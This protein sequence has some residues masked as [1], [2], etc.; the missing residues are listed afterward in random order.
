MN[1]KILEVTTFFSPVV[2]GVETQVSDLSIQLIGKGY[3]VEV[4]TTNSNR[5]GGRKLPASEVIKVEQYDPVTLGSIS[6]VPINVT[7]VNTWF[8]LS[9]FHKFAPGFLLKL[10]QRDFDIVHV[11][12]IRKP[13]LYWAL[14]VAK[15]KRKKIVVSTHNPFT[16]VNRSLLMRLYIFLHDITFGV[17]LMRFVDKYVLL[18]DTEIEVLKKFGIAE[19]KMIVL[20]NALN[21]LFSSMLDESTDLVDE[22]KKT[23]KKLLLEDLGNQF[24]SIKNTSWDAI[25]F[26]TGRFNKVKGFQ[27]L[28]LAAQESP[29]SLFV[30]LGGDDGFGEQL[31]RQF[32]QSNNVVLLTEF[33]ARKELARMFRAADLF[34]LPSLHE[35]FGIVIIEA[36]SQGCAIVA[37]DSAGPRTITKNGKF[38]VLVPPANEAELSAAIKRLVEVKSDL[39]S[40]QQ[41]SL[42]RAKDF[43]W[44]KILAKYTENVFGI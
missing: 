7:R 44:N 6:N 36:M 41:L 1:Q 15:L 14:L 4:L 3:K 37:T 16:T 11:H 40:Y 31:Q 5:G 30:I 2:G 8:S 18:A 9:Q 27:Y 21:P 24:P 33:V 13:E 29:G 20:G 19:S 22:L 34:V 35:P 12:G 28:D 25:V 43:T 17:L 23:A 39:K 10:W 32:V 42:K 38:G 26:A